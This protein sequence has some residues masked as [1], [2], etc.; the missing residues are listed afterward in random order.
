MTS[1]PPLH[2]TMLANYNLAT[3]ELVNHR[4]HLS[5]HWQEMNRHFSRYLQQPELWKNFRRNEISQ[6]MDDSNPH[7]NMVSPENLRPYLESNCSQ[8]KQTIRPDIAHFQNEPLTG[9]PVYHRIA[10]MNITIPSQD[11]TYFAWR[12]DASLDSRRQAPLLFLEIGGGFGGL[13]R[14]LKKLF[15]NA[16]FILLDLPEGNAT[17]TYFLNK[18]FPDS[19]FFYL[20][21]LRNGEH[22]DWA[23]HDFAIL[24]GWCSES[25]AGEI[26][27]FAINTRSMQEM[28]SETISYYFAEI[29]RL[30]KIGGLF[31]CVNRYNKRIGDENIILADYPYDDRWEFLFSTPKWNQSHIHELTSRRLAQ[32]NPNFPYPLLQNLPR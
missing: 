1:L 20:D 23:V 9:N 6:G 25:I 12:I 29:Q 30:L 22:I 21:N 24:P 27:D 5:S 14:V 7:E 28:R 31:Y 16:K 15:T 19:Q 4:A 10:N 18:E 3:G 2:Q 8:I 26:I 11:F 13:T 32:P 17:S